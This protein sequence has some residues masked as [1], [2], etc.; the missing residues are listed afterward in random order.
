MPEITPVE[1]AWHQ[2]IE[3][4]LSKDVATA[5]DILSKYGFT[6]TDALNSVKRITGSGVGI[7]FQPGTPSVFRDPTHQCCYALR[8]LLLVQSIRDADP[9][10]V[11]IGRLWGRAAMGLEFPQIAKAM[12]SWWLTSHRG[13]GGAKVNDLTQTLAKILRDKPDADRKYVLDYLTSEAA[14]DAFSQTEDPTIHITGVEID[15]TAG[16]LSYENR[17]RKLNKI[18]LASLDRR[19]RDLRRG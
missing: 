10:A 13:I 3:T 7:V 2:R 11:Q 6:P 12:Q 8:L 4:M 19:I 9:I 18:K 1:I 15:E 14:E 5:E 17:A 16:T